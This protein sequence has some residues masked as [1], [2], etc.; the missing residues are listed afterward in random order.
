MTTQLSDRLLPLEGGIN[1]RDMGGY[2]AGDGKTVKWRRLYR[3]G[4]MGRLTPAD[5]EHLNERGIRTVIDFRT[6]EEQESEPNPLRE[7]EG[8]SYWSRLH[9]E[10]FGNLHEMVDKGIPTLEDARQVMLNGFRGLPFQ[11][12][13]AYRELFQRI[14]EGGTPVVFHC[15]AGKDRTGGAAALLLSALD[16]PRD[17]I[18]ADFALTEQAVDLLKAFR[19]RPDP[20]HARYA[21]L[22]P[23]VASA[24]GGAHPS[25]IS[26]MLDFLD[27]K[28]GSVEGYL[29]EIGLR[30]G[31]LEAV[32]AELLE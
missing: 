16:V 6:A 9:N 24:I 11:Q 15:T 8:V 19:A 28:Y 13:E 25:Y 29:L 7:H 30:P 31:D 3:S 27:E 18:L 22:S 1:F 4:A 14:A 21:S 10:T 23:E 5:F 20:K 32:R 26:A 17:V 2:T 12:A